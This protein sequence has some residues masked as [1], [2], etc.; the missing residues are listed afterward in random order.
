MRQARDQQSGGYNV[1]VSNCACLFYSSKF[2]YSASGN[3]RLEKL[4]NLRIFRHRDSS[5]I[6]LKPMQNR[7]E[8]RVNLVVGAES[9]L[10]ISTTKAKLE[11]SLPS[12][13]NSSAGIMLLEP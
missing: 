8:E 5:E 4:R 1:R 10:F 7:D 12:E 13:N 6:R 9:V 11:N 2:V 3:T